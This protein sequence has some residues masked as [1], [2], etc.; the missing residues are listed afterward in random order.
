VKPP[1]ASILLLSA[2]VGGSLAVLPVPRAEA[3]VVTASLVKTTWTGGPNSNWAHPSPD[4]SGITYNSRTRQLLISDGEVEET[5]S[6]YPNNVWEGTNLFPAGLGGNLLATGLN[7][8]AYSPE[9]TGVGFRPT[10]T[11]SSGHTFPERLF[12]SDD[13]A[14]RVFEVNAVDGIYGNSNDTRTSF[15]V[16]FLSEGPEADAEDVAVDLA[17][18][19]NGQVLLMDGLNQ[20]VFVYNPGPDR[21]FNGQGS[22]GDFIERVV[23]VGSFGAGDPEGIAYNAFRN[24]V[25]VLDDPS[26]TIYELSMTGALLNTVPVPV[27]MGSGAGIVL[28]PPSNGSAGQNAYIV[29]RGVDNDTS[30]SSFNDGRLYEV[31]IP[32]LTGSTGSTN[33][34]PTVSAGA[35]SSVTLP[36]SASL[37]GTVSDAT[38]TGTLTSSWTET[39]GPGTVTFGNPSLVDTTASFSATGTYVLRLT[40]TDGSASA[41]DEVT[42][43]VRP[44][45]TGGGTVTVLDI[46]VQVSS[47]DAEQRGT[48][49][50]LTSGDLNLVTDGATVQ[51]VGMRFTGVGVPKGATITNAYV[52]FQ[53]DEVSTAT[54]SLT[55]AGQAADS[56]TTFTTAS[57]DVGNRSRTNARAAWTPVPWPTADAR[58][59][60]QRT[61]DLSAVV[62]EVVN[63]PG[64]TTG[65]P[66]ALIVT[67][68]GSRIAESFD[69]GAAKAPVLHIE[70]GSGSG[71]TTN[72]PPTVSAGTDQA[73]TL[74]GGA[75]LD[76]TVTDS[77][78]TTTLTSTW[79]Q[80]SGPGSVT[81]GDAAAVDTTATFSAAG[82]YVL[83]LAATDG[84]A[85][86]EDDVTVQVAPASGG[87][88]TNGPP[89]VSAGADQTVT[90]PT[91]A[92]LDA[93]VTDA[94]P[95]G[96]LTTTWTEVSGPGAVTFGNAA[97]VDTSANF[98]VDGT[99]L[100]RLTATDGAATAQDEVQVV[101]R[102]ASTGG[103]TIT[104]LD[105]PVR[106]SADDAEQRGTSVTL[107]SGDLNLVTDGSSVQTVGM[108]FTGVGVPDGAVITNAYVQFQVDEVSTVT[109]SLTIAGQAADSAA[110]FTTAAADITNRSRT[111]A[112]AAWAPLPWSTVNARTTDQRTPNL[113]SVVQEIVDRPSW[114]SGN[115][116]ALIITGTGA[117]VAESFDGGAA[118]APVLHIEY[119]TS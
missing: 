94:T 15:D 115:P 59:A 83:R 2:L 29:D 70:Y 89:T 18:T 40:A 24:T 34:P 17:P 95:T 49:V 32:G 119:R 112:S 16:A 37:D 93:A 88:T 13:D 63:R 105:I 43:V 90:L 107:S 27:R 7:T 38:P 26:N 82:T 75:T 11:A 91:A 5:G 20:R 46:P 96:T 69:G 101:V 111:T 33:Q 84:S 99:Y 57:G 52:Q 87:G 30:Q 42:V 23:D 67:G 44:A 102:P 108:R 51:T 25:F 106:V 64:W 109:T 74:P 113:A 61:S 92:S 65:N 100:L 19:R 31:A 104:V 8:M 58:T 77:T 66:V 14:H 41:F 76:G 22:G 98:S 80:V 116:V 68:S 10:F 35:D 21:I 72:G 56:A 78:P 28:A 39:S 73:V 48:S 47:D 103:S 12:V 62:Q 114:L 60:D 55:I 3:A 79:S 97:A 117:R 81:F 54:T 1:S 36:S 45:S 71:G 50:A 85:S 53:V 86:A 4:P 118:K 110:T 9:P 6:A